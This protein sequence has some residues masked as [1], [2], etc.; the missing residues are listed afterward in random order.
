MKHPNHTIRRIRIGGLK[1][2]SIH[3]QRKNQPAILVIG[4][5]CKTTQRRADI[6]TSNIFWWEKISLSAIVHVNSFG[7]PTIGFI[8]LNSITAHPINKYKY[9]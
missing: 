4:L 5:N 6:M 7:K 2:K 8:S 3:A 1:Y 9:V